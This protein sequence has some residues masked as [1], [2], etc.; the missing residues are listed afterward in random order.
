MHS[1]I[2]RF[3]FS[4]KNAILH[5]T[6]RNGLENH[7]PKKRS[8]CEIIHMDKKWENSLLALRYELFNS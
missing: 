1:D 4:F 6:R 2:K 8:E 3:L 5:G 7:N